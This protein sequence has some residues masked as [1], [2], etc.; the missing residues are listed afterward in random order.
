MHD[1]QKTPPQAHDE[2]PHCYDYY[3]PSVLALHLIH[4]L[5]RYDDCRGACKYRD[6]SDMVH[7]PEPFALADF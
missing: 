1:E 5:R 6:F 4:S 3:N 2:P 7:H